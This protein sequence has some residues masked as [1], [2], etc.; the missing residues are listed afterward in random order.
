M[1]TQRQIVT[2]ISLDAA[3]QAAIDPSLQ[4]VLFD[5]ALNLESPT[6]LPVDIEHVVAAIV[7]AARDNQLDADHVIVANDDDLIKVLT[8][9]VKSVFALYG[10]RLGRDE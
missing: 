7:I 9:H 4:D 10:G 6:S 5:L 1:N 8:P 3:G 2:G